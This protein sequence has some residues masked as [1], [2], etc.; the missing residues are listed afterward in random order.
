MK[1]EALKSTITLIR[2]E[3]FEYN[4]KMGSFKPEFEGI[5]E[6]YYPLTCC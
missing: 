1:D 4:K 5:P 6:D 2:H 3:E